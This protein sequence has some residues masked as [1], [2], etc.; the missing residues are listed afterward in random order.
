MKASDISAKRSKGVSEMTKS[1]DISPRR[2]NQIINA[3]NCRMHPKV[4]DPPLERYELEVFR[5]MEAQ[6]TESDST[7]QQLT[8]KNVDYDRDDPYRRIYQYDSID[9][10]I[11]P[12][13]DLP[14][15]LHEAA[16]FA[17]ERCSIV[18][19]ME[20]MQI[21]LGQ[22]CSTELAAAGVLH[23]LDTDDICCRFGYKVPALIKEYSQNISEGFG[24][25]PEYLKTC[26]TDIRR[27]ALADAVSAL[28]DFVC[29]QDAFSEIPDDEKSLMAR[30][31]RRMIDLL[32][33]FGKEEDTRGDYLELGSL[34]KHLF[35]EFFILDEKAIYMTIED[36][37][38][39]FER[40]ELSWKASEG[41]PGEAV[42]A[43][44]AEA[45][46]LEDI[47]RYLAS[48]PD[49]DFTVYSERYISLYGKIRN[50]CMT[51]I[52][53]VEGDDYSSL[54]RYTFSLDETL[55][56]LSKVSLDDFF[57]VCREGHLEG[58]ELFLRK[59]SIEYSSMLI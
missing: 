37:I 22:G 39:V 33:D 57:D 54:K 10:S 25:T 53:E 56:L 28:R 42:R 4:I 47:W 13:R 20:V 7:G 21:L 45:E 8:F 2:W 18:H 1:G 38:Y 41:L 46:H 58:M 11:I 35:A 55:R 19:P 15:K 9:Y 52:S 27:L 59:N 29:D 50:G 48:S 16:R 49:R 36:E 23:D 3:V 5:R 24:K 43:D 31:Y 26:S 6:K 51:L 30:Y 12:E 17:A 34:Y 44:K 14:L 32:R 40:D